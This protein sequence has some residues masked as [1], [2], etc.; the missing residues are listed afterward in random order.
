MS[1]MPGNVTGENKSYYENVKKRYVI[2]HSANTKTSFRHFTLKE[3]ND[4]RLLSVFNKIPIVA[5]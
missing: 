5:I 1:Y 2:T 3:E 4:S